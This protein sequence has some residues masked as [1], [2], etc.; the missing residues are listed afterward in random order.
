MAALSSTT[1]TRDVM[2]YSQPGAAP[3]RC[4]VGCALILTGHLT[5]AS[6]TVVAGLLNVAIATW[7]LMPIPSLDG[8]MIW[9]MLTPSSGTDAA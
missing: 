1:S 5:E 7:T 2:I 3:S 8:W 9:G 4:R 6:W